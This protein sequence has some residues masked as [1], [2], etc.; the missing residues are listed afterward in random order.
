MVK[1]I[2]ADE[3]LPEPVAVMTTLELPAVALAEAENVRVVLQ[4]TVQLAEENKAV[5]PAGKA[6]AVND[7]AV[8]LP[9]VSVAVM[10]SADD[11]PCA[12]D[13]LELAADTEKVV[14]G[15]GAAVANV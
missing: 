15:G 5:T 14:D 8:A 2:V 4:V 1:A 6:D 9:E 7:T 3:V 10:T 13:R 12:T 11:A